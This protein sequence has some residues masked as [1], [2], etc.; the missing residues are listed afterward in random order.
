MRL[1]VAVMLAV[2]VADV[3]SGWVAAHS[4]KQARVT[5]HIAI[6]HAP[7]VTQRASLAA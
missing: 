4:L 6:S 1:T 3:S 2:G 7:A 5:R